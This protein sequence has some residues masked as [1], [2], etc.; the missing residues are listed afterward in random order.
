MLVSTSLYRVPADVPEDLDH[1]S[2]RL[3]EQGP[4]PPHITQFLFFVTTL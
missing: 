2:F 1:D 3:I 4:R